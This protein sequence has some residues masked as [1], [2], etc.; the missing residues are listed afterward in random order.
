MIY[1]EEC[2][3]SLKEKQALPLE[4]KL[5]M[6][7][8]RI[9]EWHKYWKGECYVSFSGGKDS[10][11]LLHM[12]R[13]IYPDTAAVFSNTGL[14]FPE[15]FNFIRETSNV[16]VIKPKISFNA[17][18]KKYGYPVV[19]KE[20]AR[21]LK[22][23]QNPTDHNKRTIDIRLGLT[24]SAVG[25]CPKKWLYLKDAPFKISDACCDVMKKRPMKVYE[26]N[27]KKPFLGMMAHESRYRRDAYRRNG[28]N[29]FKLN[30]PSSSPMSFWTEQDVWD[31][32]KLFNVPY[33]TIYDMGYERT[34]CVFCMFG[35]HLD[36][37]AMKGLNRFQLLKQTH[38]KL[39]A[40]CMDKLD[41]RVV[42]GFLGLPIE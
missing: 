2:D 13:D 41:L 5:A 9:M 14:E 1:P 31:Y 23:L 15:I 28:C 22:D 19:S 29:A 7:R 20:T 27:N 25:K 11:V 40:Y 32:I 30:R 6:T 3:M 42:M 36:H 21:K 26:K 12:A 35:V 38:P 24:G 16:T 18:I 10:T 34:G 33:S 8:Y 4:T 17:V 37:R 39:W